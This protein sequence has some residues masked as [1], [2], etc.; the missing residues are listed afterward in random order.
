MR[1]KR[2][3]ITKILFFLVV[4]V[5]IGLIG[6]TI[7]KQTENKKM[8]SIESIETQYKKQLS[9][10]LSEQL[11]TTRDTYDSCHYLMMPLHYSFK[12]DE[13]ISCRKDFKNLFQRFLKDDKKEFN[14]CNALT[15]NHFIYLCSQYLLLSSKYE[16]SLFLKDLYDFC[17]EEMRQYCSIY[18]GNWEAGIQYKDF[19]DVLDGILYGKGYGMNL[20][21]DYAITDNDLFPLAIMCDL[22]VAAKNMGGGV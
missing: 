16:E 18:K 1:Y 6:N 2:Y 4:I 13:F 22:F 20:S 3:P 5:G 21:T 17:L 14:Q 15:R 7:Y 10:V 9:N 12:N 11:W 8:K 19:Y